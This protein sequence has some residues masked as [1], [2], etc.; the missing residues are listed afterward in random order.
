MRKFIHDYSRLMEPLPRQLEEEFQK[1]GRR[2]K[3]ELHKVTLEWKEE[4]STVF[5]SLK[6]K[7]A[8]AN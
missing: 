5:D 1:A 7:L 6:K 3:K 4:H 8:E 2:T